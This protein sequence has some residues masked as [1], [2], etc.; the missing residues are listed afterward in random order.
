MD[1]VRV[2]FQVAA[3]EKEVTQKE[4]TESNRKYFHPRHH[5]F[6]FQLGET[7]LEFLQI[8]PFFAERWNLSGKLFIHRYLF[9]CGRN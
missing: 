6:P 2:H 8:P 1:R 3:P 7:E 4:Q 5:S 9:H